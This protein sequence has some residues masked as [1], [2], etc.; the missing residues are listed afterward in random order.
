[1]FSKQDC[2][3]YFQQIKTLETSMVQVFNELYKNVSDP[4]LKNLFYEISQDE[5]SHAK[6]IKDIEFLIKDLLS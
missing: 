5:I 1:M 3:E 2:L 4:Y 6:E